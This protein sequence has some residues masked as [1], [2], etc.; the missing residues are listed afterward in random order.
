MLGRDPLVA[1]GLAQAFL[2]RGGP[3][4]I[5]PRFEES[6]AMKRAAGPKSCLAVHSSQ[7]ALRSTHLP[8][9]FRTRLPNRELSGTVS[10]GKVRIVSHERAPR[11]RF[12]PPRALICRYRRRDAAADG[13]AGSTGK[14]GRA[15]AGSGSRRERTREP[16]SGAGRRPLAARRRTRRIAGEIAPAGARQS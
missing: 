1:N 16:D 12:G 5:A 3:G 10:P 9:K 14:R 6:K 7:P 11:Q 2:A 13:G 8:R 4:W 15:A